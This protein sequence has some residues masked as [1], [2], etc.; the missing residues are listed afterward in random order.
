MTSNKVSFITSPTLPFL[1][2]SKNSFIVSKKIYD[3]FGNCCIVISFFG[4]VLD[5]LE[6]CLK[7]KFFVDKRDDAI[8]C[9]DSYIP[10][11]LEGTWRKF[12]KQPFIRV[13]ITK[14]TIQ[15]CFSIPNHRSLLINRHKT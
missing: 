10:I 9:C 3:I 13:D 7:K 6:N 5:C 4:I 2:K 11:D 12:Y 14:K 15:N 1:K 8:L